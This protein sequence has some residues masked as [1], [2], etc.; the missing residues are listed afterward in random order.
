MRE[1]LYNIVNHQ[2]GNTDVKRSKDLKTLLFTI[3]SPGDEHP[4]L[5]ENGKPTKK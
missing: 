1:D 2:Q 5:T 4:E 3:F